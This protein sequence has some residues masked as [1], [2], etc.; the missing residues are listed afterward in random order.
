MGGGVEEFPSRLLDKICFNLYKYYYLLL[1]GNKLM[2]SISAVKARAPVLGGKHISAVGVCM[3]ILPTL[4]KLQ[5][6][7]L[8]Q[9]Y[10]F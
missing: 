2:G 7:V 4:Y 1:Q 10:I 5:K 3:I 8:E 6:F 9:V